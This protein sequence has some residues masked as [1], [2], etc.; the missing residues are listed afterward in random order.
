MQ[1]TL[2]VDNRHPAPPFGITA[3]SCH[4]ARIVTVC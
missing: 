3:K 4:Q 2:L 1:S